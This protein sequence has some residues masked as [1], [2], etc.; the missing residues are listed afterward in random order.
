MPTL[1]YQKQLELTSGGGTHNL[2]VSDSNTAYHITSAGL[3]TL[4]GSWTI[5]SSGT[6]YAGSK[7][8]FNY[9]ASINLNGNQINFFGTNMPQTLVNQ[10]CVVIAYYDGSSWS[11]NFLPTADGVSNSVMLSFGK[12]AAINASANANLLTVNAIDSLAQGYVVPS[13]GFLKAVG[14]VTEVTGT[15]ND[16]NA[17]VYIDGVAT[18]L[19]AS[20]EGSVATIVTST[21]AAANGLSVNAGQRIG[22]KVTNVAGGPTSFTNT[23]ATVQITL[24]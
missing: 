20:I 23:T 11:V 17:V 10:K 1:E 3:V 22:V 24:S 12:A 15:G 14:V 6:P 4:A 19:S 5:Q 2:P 9:A 16:G 13:A 8:F 18:T 7:Y 21:G